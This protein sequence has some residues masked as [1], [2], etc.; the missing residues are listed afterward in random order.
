LK[1]YAIRQAID[2]I[3]RNLILTREGKHRVVL[4]NRTEYEDMVQKGI[5]K[6]DKGNAN[7]AILNR[8][9]NSKQKSYYVQEDV[10]E[11]YRKNNN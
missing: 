1:L 9:K 3:C 10:V 11:L 6:F 7:V 2:K 4:V 5:I 8:Q